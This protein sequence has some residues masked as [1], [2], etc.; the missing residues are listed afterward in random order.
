MNIPK[1]YL[2]GV[3]LCTAP[4]VAQAQTLRFVQGTDLDTLDPAVT[5]STPSHIVVTHVFNRLVDWDGPKLQKIVP[6]LAESWTNSAD[7]KTWTFKLR[8]NVKFH[9]GTPFNAAAVKVS[10]D[11]IRDAA[12]GS[13]NRSYYALIES[14]ATPADDVVVITTSQPMPTLLEVLAEEWSSIS[15]PTALQKSGRAYG[16]N[17]VGT[18]PYVFKSW[19][20]G[21]KVVLERNPNYF[22]T[23]GKPQQLEFRPVPEGSARVIELQTGNADVVTHIPPESADE[24]KR[25]GKAELLVVPSSFQVF[26]ELNTAKPPFNDV[27]MRKAVNLAIDRKAIVEKVLNGYGKV[28]ESPM[29]PGVQGRRAFAPYPFDPAQARK[30]IKEAFPN[31]YNEPIVMWT[32]SGRYVKDRAVAEAVQGYLNDVGLKTEFKVWEWATYQKTLYA[33]KPG[34]GTGKGSNDAHM[35][36]LGTGITN[37][38]TRLRRKLV[39]SDTSNLTGYTHPQ[40]EKLL[41]E[42]SSEMNYEKRMA[43]YGEV[44]KIV[45]QDAPYSIP[46]FDQVQL[47]GM[48]KG[49]TGATIFPDEIFELS[50]VILK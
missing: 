30:L 44:Q 37:A 39:G 5:R 7:G 38:D 24:I 29:A 16:R 10:L 6:D 18:G 34:Q 14:I 41:N 28:P 13:P 36:L 22:G 27:R 25:G 12:L 1:L 26:F 20:Q 42:A 33:P 21:E 48:R 40:V 45:W 49:L 4:F 3:M 9:D 8:H 17:P 2:A 11:R 43:K 46:L 50:G 15:S 32:S 47:V 23:A 31:G 19:V 35:W